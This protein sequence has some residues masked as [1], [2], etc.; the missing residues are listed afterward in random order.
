MK[1]KR[2]KIFQGINRA[3]NGAIYK[4]KYIESNTK[5]DIRNDIHGR[6]YTP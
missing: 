5:N 3:S 1:N 2:I 4:K 6:N